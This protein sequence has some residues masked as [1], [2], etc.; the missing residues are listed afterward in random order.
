MMQQDEEFMTSVYETTIQELAE[1]VQKW[2]QQYSQ[3][4]Y[5]MREE[6][7]ELTEIVREQKQ[8]I[9][10]LNELVQKMSTE[11]QQLRRRNVVGSYT[12]ENQMDD[13]FFE[14]HV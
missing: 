5:A 1:E 6:K 14:M 9:R 2:K 3:A 8:E 11:I 4:V 12:Q 10:Q 13:C 7:E